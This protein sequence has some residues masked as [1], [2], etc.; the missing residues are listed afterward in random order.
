MGVIADTVSGPLEDDNDDD[1][2]GFYFKRG[3]SL[4]PLDATG[5]CL[6]DQ[7]CVILGHQRTLGARLALRIELADCMCDY[8]EDVRFL[9][10]MAALREV[11]D[12]QAEDAITELE[13]GG[14]HMQLALAAFQGDAAIATVTMDEPTEVSSDAIA[15]VR[16]AC[17]LSG[18]E[19]AQVRYVVLR[20]PAWALAEKIRL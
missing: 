5:D 15:A 3:I 1:M 11:T 7:L 16:C 20:M 6:I 10:S 2:A 18:A 8:V 17:N 9:R 13:Q 19:I 12:L 4:L 14:G